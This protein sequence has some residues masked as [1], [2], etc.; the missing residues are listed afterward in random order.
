MLKA[1]VA[2]IAG[3]IERCVALTPLLGATSTAQICAR[4]NNASRENLRL[5]QLP[6]PGTGGSSF[7][8][9]QMLQ[10]VKDNFVVVSATFPHFF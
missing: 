7:S 5:V 3:T 4:R 2:V 9:V 10:F 1:A 6:Q 8:A